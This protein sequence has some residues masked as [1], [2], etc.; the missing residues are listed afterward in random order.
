LNEE[1]SLTD[2]G[3]L[4]GMEDEPPGGPP[5]VTNPLDMNERGQILVSV[6]VYDLSGAA[7]VL[8]YGVWESGVMTPLPSLGGGRPF[9]THLNNHGEVVGTDQTGPAAPAHLVLWSPG[10]SRGKQSP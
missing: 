1:G 5:S 8:R 10:A 2:L 6:Y 3:T 9:A 4:G 7:G